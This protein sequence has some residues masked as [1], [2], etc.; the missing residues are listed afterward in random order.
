[1]SYIHEQLDVVTKGAA[2]RMSEATTFVNL[3]INT[4]QN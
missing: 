3:D 2:Q 1:M 4:P